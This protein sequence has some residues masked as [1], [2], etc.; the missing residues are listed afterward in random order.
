MCEGD[1]CEAALDALLLPQWL[2]SIVHFHYSM[3][4][5]MPCEPSHSHVR[6]SR[7][8]AVYFELVFRRKLQ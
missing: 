8:T 5:D 7:S 1:V 3:L 2:S 6:Q 4:L